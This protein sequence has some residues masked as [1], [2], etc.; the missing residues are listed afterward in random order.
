MYK[1]YKIGDLSKLLNIPAQN[2]RFY[3]EK[4]I[5]SPEKDD[6]TGYRFYSAWNLNDLLDTLHYRGLDFSLQEIAN[7]LKTDSFDD[8][9]EAYKTKENEI[10]EKIAKYKHILEMLSN[11]RVRLQ[12]L[13]QYIGSFETCMSPPLIFHRHRLKNVLQDKEGNTDLN[14]LH[15]DLKMWLDIIPEAFATF[16][17][18]LHSLKNTKPSEIEYWYGFS[19]HSETALKHDI[20]ATSQN[21]YLPVSYCIYTIFDAKEE[22][23]FMPCFYEQVYRKIIDMNYIIN[24]SPFG[25]LLTKTHEKNG[26]HRY[27]EVWVPIVQ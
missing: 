23:S 14:N 9:C 17:I 2:I 5:I 6:V 8:I 16:Y 3:E 25:R 7:M 12:N 19:V 21:E 26:Y 4:G 10:L 13:T 15:N 22:G 11:E 18:P 1:K 24:G 27:F 20:K